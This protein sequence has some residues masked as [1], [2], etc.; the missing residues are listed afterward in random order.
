MKTYQKYLLTGALVFIAAALML[1]KY[2]DY[3]VNPWTRDGQVRAQV[4]QITPRV[5]API[6]RP[7]TC[8]LRSIHVRL[9]RP[10]NRN[11]LS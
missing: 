7:A 2:W 1:Y 4:V 6:I 3:A 9:K 11:A 10:W 5:S 8:C